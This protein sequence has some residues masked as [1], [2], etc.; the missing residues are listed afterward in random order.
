MNFAVYLPLLRQAPVR[1]LLLVAVAARFPHAAA[2]VLLTL[3]IVET[4]G[5]GYAAAGT[6][7]AVMTVGF[8]TGAPWRGRRVDSAGLRRALLPSVVGEAAIWSAA[9]FLPY[10][11]L[12]VAALAGGILALPV[13]SVVRQCLGVLVA[14]AQLRTAYALD[15]IGTELTFMA[16]P[17][18]GVLLATQLSTALGLVLI[19]VSSAAAGLL[20]IWLNPPTRTP[21]DTGDGA[22]PAIAP[23]TPAAG[24]LRA[25][26]AWL[27]AGVA[28]VLAAAAGAGLLLT[29][30]DVGIV[31]ALR[32]GGN[33]EQLGL[34]F[35]FWCGASLVGGLLYGALHR[36]VSPLVLLAVMG[37]LT[38]PLGLSSDPWTLSLLSIA[39]GL[40]CAPVLAAASER[41]AALVPEDRRGEAMGWYGSALTVGSAL[42][43]P[44]A[45]TVIDAAGARG[46]F[47]AVGT[48]AVVLA[49]AGLAARSANRVRRRRLAPAAGSREE[50]PPGGEVSSPD[51]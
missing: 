39:P 15:S 26:F 50:V 4:L 35:L 20:L 45:G 24:R 22:A 31:A 3:H 8:A 36:S 38:I 40:L 14:P 34:V 37:V 42:G 9:P 18:A 7:A 47:A 1:R 32:Q 12:L 19:G 29:G 51:R 48:A 43:S 13:F 17:A 33:V 27:T 6:V 30:T 41:V 2:G 49:L 25:S 23:A 11:W 46:G 10:S 44:L 28:A 5:L 16:G 21:A